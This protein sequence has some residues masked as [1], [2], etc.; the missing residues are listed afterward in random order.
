MLLLEE[1]LSVAGECVG[2]DVDNDVVDDD[3]SFVFDC[4]FLL[5]LLYGY[6]L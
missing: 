5:N 3:C 1:E 4:A 6:L 2:D